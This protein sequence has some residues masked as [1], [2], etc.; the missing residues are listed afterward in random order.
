MW[1][2]I[3]NSCRH[4]GGG[5]SDCVVALETVGGSVGGGMVVLVLAIQRSGEDEGTTEWRKRS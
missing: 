2:V 1:E 5:C 4:G 3:N